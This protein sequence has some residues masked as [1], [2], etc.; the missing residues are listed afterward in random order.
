MD[1]RD[2]LLLLCNVIVTQPTVSYVGHFLLCPGTAHPQV[3]SF[4]ASILIPQSEKYNRGNFTLEKE[5]RVNQSRLKDS[6]EQK[7]GIIVKKSDLRILSKNSN[8]RLPL[9]FK[10]AIE[11]SIL[12]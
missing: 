3:N 2:T 4:F 5:V 9:K 12:L 8:T 1:K 11:D 6:L 7:T 10:N